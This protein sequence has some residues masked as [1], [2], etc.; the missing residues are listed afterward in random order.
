M[1]QVCECAP[2]S[3]AWGSVEV[4]AA[5]RSSRA[6][7]WAARLLQEEHAA[8]EL[9]LST[10]NRVTRWRRLL[11]AAILTLVG[12]LLAYAV[13]MNVF[14]RTRSFRNVLNGAQHD[15]V[16]EYDRAYSILPGRIHVEGLSIRGADYNVEWV[17]SI[18]RCDFV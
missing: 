5:P 16:V 3:S 17:L 13:A 14:L 4:V 2:P 12:A 6:R 18:R 8:C 1:P 7:C 10:S 11:R 15:I 9:S